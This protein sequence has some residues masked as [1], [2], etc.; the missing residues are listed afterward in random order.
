M[1]EEGTAAKVKAGIS[2]RALLGRFRDLSAKNRAAEHDDTAS[3]Y[4]T[5]ITFENSIS[6]L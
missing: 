2:T 6:S 3:E 4:L 1:T 5:S